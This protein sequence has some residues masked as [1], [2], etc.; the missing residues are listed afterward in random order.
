MNNKHELDAL[1][2]SIN[3][4]MYELSQTDVRHTVSVT[5]VKEGLGEDTKEYR[6]YQIFIR[7]G[8]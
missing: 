2:S 5:D 6:E 8:K 1:I 7:I 4:L 3:K